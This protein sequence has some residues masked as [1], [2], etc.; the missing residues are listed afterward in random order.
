MLLP[1]SLKKVLSSGIAVRVSSNKAANGIATVSIARAAAKRAGIKVGKA[2]TV[3]I[4]LGTVSSVTNGTVTLRL[5]L[6]PAIARKLRRLRHLTM[7]VRLALIAAGNQT[8]AV[9]EAARF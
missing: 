1:Q 3:R 2:A 6:S 7:T 4:G 5:H 8:Y 9:D